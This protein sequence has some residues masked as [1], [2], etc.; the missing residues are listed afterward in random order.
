MTRFARLALLLAA[1]G[2]PAFI[3]GCTEEAPTTE[4][5]AATTPAPDAPGAPPAP[6]GAA[7]AAPAAPAK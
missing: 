2:T 1:L 3:V 4:T 6:G 5:P 7:P